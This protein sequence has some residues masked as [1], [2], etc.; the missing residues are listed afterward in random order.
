MSVDLFHA[1]EQ[2]ADV[3][4]VADRQGVIQYVNRAFET[5]TGYSRDQAI[6]RTPALLRSGVQTP[7]FYTML[8]NTILCGRT[9]RS[10]V[11]DR[12]QDG[13]LFDL[14]QTITPIR[15]A[16]GDI[17]QFLAIGRDVTESRRADAARVHHQLERESSRIATLL[18]ADTGQFL[19]A[20]LLALSDAAQAA[21]PDTRVRLDEVRRCV[22]RV[23]QQLRCATHGMEP[24][25]I[26]EVGLTE[27]LGLL[28]G[29]AA[30]RNA[31]KV[32]IDSSI[33]RRCPAAIETLIYKFVQAALE[34]LALAEGCSAASVALSR[35]INGRR[36][37]DEVM[38]CSVRGEATGTPLVSAVDDETSGLGLRLVRNRLEA[39]GGALA[40]VASSAGME[41]R[42]TVPLRG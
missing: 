15:D 6:G 27:A 38:C 12:A 2:A 42:V 17:A 9:F 19:A 37:E 4:M 31:I 26:A 7:R 34:H 16:S 40:V 20:A 8:W 36:A 33:E 1:L 22:D 39:L 28:A 25:A 13:R 30:R 21:P 35:E 3:V 24:R 29:D 32:T 18:H 10:V 23:E 41:L 11:S 14:E 5:T